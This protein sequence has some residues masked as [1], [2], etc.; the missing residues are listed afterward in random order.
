MEDFARYMRWTAA[1]AVALILAW[2]LLRRKGFS[3]QRFQAL[4][5]WAVGITIVAVMAGDMAAP[6]SIWS[7]QFRLH[8]GVFLAATIVMAQSY[9]KGRTVPKQSP[10]VA[11]GRA[12]GRDFYGAGAIG[13]SLAWVAYEH[14]PASMFGGSAGAI[15]DYGWALLGAAWGVVLNP[16]LAAAGV[17]R[18]KAM[19]FGYGLATF[20]TC[21][22]L[23]RTGDLGRMVAPGLFL[24]LQIPVLRMEPKQEEQAQ[25]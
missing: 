2:T 11:R 14:L 5:R 12:R 20:A 3:F 6:G 24:I 1:A 25:Q 18:S 15:R 8:L 17:K 13:I 7:G 16:R 22:I 9:W 10:P 19:A 23:S 4:A 21:A